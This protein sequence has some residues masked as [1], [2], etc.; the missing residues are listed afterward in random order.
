MTALPEIDVL[1]PSYRGASHLDTLLPSVAAQTAPPDSIW[2]ADEEDSATLATTKSF[3]AHY[4]MLARNFGFASTVNRLLEAT[5]APYVAILNNDVRLPPNWLATL[6][7]ELER[8]PFAVGK[9][10]AWN[11]ENTLD[12][13]WDLLSLSAFPLRAGYGKA[14]S[15]FFSCRREIYFAPWTAILLRRDFL[16]HLGALDE[17]FGSFYEDVDFGLRCLAAG[18][19]GLYVP[20]AVAWHRGSATL[21]PHQARQVELSAR[22]QLLLVAKHGGLDWIRRWPREFWAGQCLSLLRSFQHRTLRP[23]LRGKREGWKKLRESRARLD[24]SLAQKLE[25]LQE[26]LF[27][28]SQQGG[29]DP[30][31]RYYWALTL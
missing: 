23:A 24:D 4:L 12:A 10:R 26:E 1:I 25:A 5:R 7:P 27:A 15:E 30:F 8:F 22:N 2:V 21:G 18:A 14:D 11:Q 9:L 29:S 31:W 6:A 28:A 3:G 16:N 19:R 20:Q 17:S 13:S